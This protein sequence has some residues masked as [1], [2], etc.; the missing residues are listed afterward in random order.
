MRVLEKRASIAVKM[1]V[2]IEGRPP[3]PFNSAN[4]GNILKANAAEAADALI[5]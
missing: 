3:P 5:A 4:Y 2:Q 1:I